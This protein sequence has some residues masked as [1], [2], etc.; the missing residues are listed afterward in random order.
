M[1]KS[2]CSIAD[3]ILAGSLGTVA[4]RQRKN[5]DAHIALMHSGL[6]AGTPVRPKFAFSIMLLEFFYHLRRR[7]LSIGV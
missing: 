2:R 1:I 7:Q 5:E 6:M 4:M 3:Q